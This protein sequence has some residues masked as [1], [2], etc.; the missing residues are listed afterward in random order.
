MGVSFA[1][2]NRWENGQTRPSVLAWQR[3]ITAEEHG[4]D[5]LLDGKP[6]SLL[7]KAPDRATARDANSLELDFSG[8]SEIVRTV[9]EAHRLAYG[10]IFNPA[11]ATETSCI[12]ALPHQRMAVYQHMLLQPRLRLLLA[13]DAGAGKTIMT[14]L[15]IK[16][17]MARGDLTR[18]LIVCPGSLV[19]QWQDELDSRFHIPFEIMTNDKLEAVR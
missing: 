16:E 3:I 5:A 10:H 18:C 19:E 7:G 2:V 1:S 17:L 11:F 6:L 15:F 8:S 12:D 14:G 4:L 13:D 9:S